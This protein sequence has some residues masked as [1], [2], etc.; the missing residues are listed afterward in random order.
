[1][2]PEAKDEAP[3]K[4]T[5]PVSVPV[6]PLDAASVVKEPAAGVVPPIVVPSIAPPFMST[7]VKVLVPVEVTLPVRLPVNAVA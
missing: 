5:A 2:L 4:E 3:V 1:M 6:I 7:V